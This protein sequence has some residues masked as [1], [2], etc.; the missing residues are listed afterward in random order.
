[1]VLSP[2]PQFYAIDQDVQIFASTMLINS[3]MVKR[4]ALGMS[5]IVHRADWSW[6]TLVTEYIPCGD[7]REHLTVPSEYLS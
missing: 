7:K 3:A 5:R 4:I 6:N 2:G 1:M